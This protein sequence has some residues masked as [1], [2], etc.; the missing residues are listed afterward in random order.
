MIV[1]ENDDSKKISE[2]MKSN[3]KA[4]IFMVS[5]TTEEGLPKLKEFL[6]HISSRITESGIFQSPDDPVE[7]YIDGVY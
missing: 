2:M 4:P 3:S 6:S 1:E 5:N 7:F